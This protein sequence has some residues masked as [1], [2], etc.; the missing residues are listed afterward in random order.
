MGR[1]KVGV[2]GSMGGLVRQNL[3]VWYPDGLLGLFVLFRFL[4]PEAFPCQFGLVGLG[5]SDGHHQ[6]ID[7]VQNG[8]HGVSPSYVYVA[9][10]QGKDL[11]RL[12]V[13]FS[14]KRA[15]PKLICFIMLFQGVNLFRGAEG[16]CFS[17]ATLLL[18]KK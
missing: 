13:S 7:S 18:P 10:K 1:S 16:H 12:T 11:L 6:A 4:V 14:N 2:F 15:R 9:I 17:F 5:K 3:A 8:V